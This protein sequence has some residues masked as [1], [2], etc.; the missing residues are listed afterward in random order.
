MKRSS[1]RR[2]SVAR[3]AGVIGGCLVALLLWSAPAAAQAINLDFGDG[4]TTSGRLI[5]LFALLTLLS[6][7]PSMLIMVTSFVRIVIV[8]SFLRSAMGTQQAP[9][10]QVMISLALFLTF[11][12]MQPAAETA[13]REGIQPLMENRISE[14][15]AFERAIKPF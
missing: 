1:P 6:L 10:N 15:D 5:Q 13:Y 8:L 14:A 3:A 9:P 12:I 11:F 2:S 4:G 7:A